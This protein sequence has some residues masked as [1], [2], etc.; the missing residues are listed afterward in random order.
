MSF[1]AD[2]INTHRKSK[3]H[4]ILYGGIFVDF[5]DF[6]VVKVFHLMDTNHKGLQST[7][8]QFSAV[9]KQ[10]QGII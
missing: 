6:I 4:I 8:V 7:S 5:I 2:L 3:A 10:Y 9:C 1:F